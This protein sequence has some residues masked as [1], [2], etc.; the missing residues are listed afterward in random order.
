MDAQDLLIKQMGKENFLKQQK[1]NNQFLKEFASDE[2]L[3]KLDSPKFQNSPTMFEKIA[4]LAN[5]T[6]HQIERVTDPNSAANALFGDML[7]ESSM[8]DIRREATDMLNNEVGLVELFPGN[9]L[10]M[11]NHLNPDQGAGGGE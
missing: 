3:K 7:N 8:E 9:E 6:L 10:A 2:L 1:L 5:R 11:A 4:H